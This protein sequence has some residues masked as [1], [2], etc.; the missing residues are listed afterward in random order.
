MLGVT[1][2]S[3]LGKG[4]KHV[5]W[6]ETP[7]WKACVL[8]AV[9][10]LQSPQI[11]FVC[12]GVIP[13]YAQELILAIHSRITHGGARGTICDTGNNYVWH[14]PYM[15]YYLSGPSYVIFYEI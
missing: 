5:V 8:P 13:S 4:S 11:F 2:G 15:L 10:S 9:T 6:G 12:F 3:M 1:P 7:T 14:L